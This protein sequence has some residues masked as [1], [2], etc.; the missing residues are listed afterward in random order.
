MSVTAR[1]AEAMEAG[2]QGRRIVVGVDG[3]EGS[4][5]AL[6]WARDEAA[7]HGAELD[8]VHAWAPPAPVSEIAAMVT[9]TDD[10]VY[11]QAAQEVLAAA[12]SDLPAGTGDPV[13]VRSATV[14]G[15]PSTTLIER[16]SDAE[17]LVVGS[18][19]RGGFAGLLLG[20]V[21]QQCVHHASG[22]VAVVPATAPLPADGDVVVG[23]DGS[24]AS[25]A[26]LHWATDEAARRGARLAVVHAWWTPYAVP[27]MGIG[28]APLHREEL[29]EESRRLLHEMVDGTV[30]RAERRP[31]D[32]ELLP[33]E[34]PAAQGLLDRSTGA[35]LLVVGGRGR[36]GFTG[37]LL[38]SV[39][40]QCLHHAGCAVV[41]VTHR[42]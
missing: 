42:G 17:L 6:V 15:Y 27:P 34:A 39:S 36:G 16:A 21:G 24:A 12:L 5:H 28:M 41:V 32:V 11:E 29:L 25:W 37:L 18:R 22:P 8:V 2:S 13:P 9:P 31:P 33:I 40:Q 1:H 20:S 19:G 26:A 23:V 35:G 3:S 10:A 7:L 38:G 4:R 14:R 30:E